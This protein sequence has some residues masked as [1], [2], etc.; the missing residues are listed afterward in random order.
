MAKSHTD[1][2]IVLSSN[3]KTL[4]GNDE[5][6]KSETDVMLVDPGGGSRTGVIIQAGIEDGERI[7][8][9]NVADAN[10]TITFAAAGTSN[11]AGGTG[12]AIAQNAALTLFW[13]DVTNLWYPS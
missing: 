8:I 13:D 2:K 3:R 9:V 6:I 7:T 12:V 10:E 5:T 4:A 1:S 11:V